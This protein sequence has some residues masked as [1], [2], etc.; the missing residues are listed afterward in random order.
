VTSRSDEALA[1][2]NRLNSE[3]KNW[4]FEIVS[5]LRLDAEVI[6]LGRLTVD[7]T[8]KMAFGSSSEA[9][10]DEPCPTSVLLATAANAAL[11]RAARLF[12]VGLVLE[13]P[14]EQT[15]IESPSNTA[16]PPGN[17]ITQ[18]QLGALQGIARRRNLGRMEFAEMLRARFGRTDLITLTKREASELLSELSGSNGHAST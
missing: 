16:A 9:R 4:S 10:D 12:G 2:A 8:V 3:R 14:A 11:S 13:P 18:K 17:R 6:V 5:H 15:R 1:I 7:G